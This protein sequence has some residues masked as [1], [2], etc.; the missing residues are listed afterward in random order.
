MTRHVAKRAFRIVAG[1]FL[2]GATVMAANG[3][4]VLQQSCQTGFDLSE[5]LASQ[6]VDVT[7]LLGLLGC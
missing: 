6:G 7:D 5:L 3:C 2:A 1:L 4:Q